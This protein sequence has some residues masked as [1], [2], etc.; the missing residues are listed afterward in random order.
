[1]NLILTAGRATRLADVAPRGCKALTPVN[2][3]PIIEWQLDV[4][5]EATII[6]RP[7][8]RHLLEKYGEV[9][10][11][12]EGGGP[13]GALYYGWEPDGPVT[14]V[15]A[16]SFFSALPDGPDWVGVGVAGPGRKWDVVH[17]GKV[18]YR[19]PNKQAV[20]C[21][22]AYRFDNPLWLDAAVEHAWKRRTGEVGMAEIVNRH[23]SPTFAPVGSWLDVGDPQ[24]LSNACSIMRMTLGER[25]GAA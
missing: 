2:G 15:Y 20:V 3:R 9:A 8:H 23:P 16:D 1:M 22:G 12:G 24:A 25:K 10:C 11:T 7:E 17:N 5:G 18:S 21:V 19:E 4:L 14:I 6:A 13:V